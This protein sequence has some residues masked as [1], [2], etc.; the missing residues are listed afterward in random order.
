MELVRNL[1]SVRTPGRDDLVARLLEADESELLLGTPTGREQ[2]FIPTIASPIDVG[3][4]TT[5]GTV[6]YSGIVTGFEP[7]PGG[8]SVRVRVLGRT[9]MHERRLAPRVPDSLRVEIAC[10]R[11][12]TPVAGQLLDVSAGGLRVR[13]DAELAVGEA[14]QVTVHVPGAEPV[15]LTARVAHAEANATGFEVQL[16]TA[17]ARDRLVRHAFQ[18]LISPAETADG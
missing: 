17:A 15:R 3:L 12:D 2:Q 10:F 9:V 14:V 13:A 5:D 18:G 6:W 7:A 11:S 4:V 16:A 1:A 8:P